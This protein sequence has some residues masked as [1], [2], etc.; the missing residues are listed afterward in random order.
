MGV[1][2]R[3]LSVSALPLKKWAERLGRVVLTTGGGIKNSTINGYLARAVGDTKNVI[4]TVIDTPGQVII[5]EPA[6]PADGT[7][8]AVGDRDKYDSRSGSI[9]GPYTRVDIPVATYTITPEPIGFALDTPAWLASINWPSHVSSVRYRDRLRAGWLRMTTPDVYFEYNTTDQAPVDAAVFSAVDVYQRSGSAPSYVFSESAIAAMAPGYQLLCRTDLGY[10]RYEYQGG[11]MA[12][13]TLGT[14]TLC[15]IPVVKN[16]DP[17]QSVHW[18]HSGLLF[19]LMDSAAEE[20]TVWSQLWT[21]DGH[22]STFFHNGEFVA[23]T[24][25]T[26]TGFRAPATDAWNDF[27]ETNTS[28]GSRPNWVDGLD[29]CAFNGRFV[30]SARVCAL[31]GLPATGLDDQYMCGGSALM[32]FDVAPGGG[33]TATE[34]SHEV[35]AFALAAAGA[36]WDALYQAWVVGVLDPLVVKLENPVGLIVDRGRLIE[37][38]TRIDGDR[39][40]PLFLGGSIESP[41][42]FPEVYLDTARLVVRVTAVDIAGVEAAPVAHE[43]IFSTLGVGLTTPTYG[44]SYVPDPAFPALTS[45]VLSYKLWCG[46]VQAVLVSENELA[47]VM[48]TRWDI[49]YRDGT[50]YP[51]SL[52][53]IDLTTGAA[54]VRGT[55]GL[56]VEPDVQYTRAPHIDC[57]QQTVFAEDGSVAIE[58]VLLV[59]TRENNAVRIS[60]DSGV[61]WADYITFPRPRT[62]AYYVGSPLMAGV[63]HGRAIS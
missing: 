47:V 45:P 41:S 2:V 56:S 18:G 37:L 36:G 52:V 50:T 34:I 23:P 39:A 42:T 63:P 49:A 20:P 8:Y 9:D 7:L 43:V 6:D 10:M 46:G 19:V 35:W 13:A 24:A 11:A 25:F 57:I 51:I 3:I 5:P 30:V 16:F 53:V 21:P 32:R 12:T 40:T 60:R 28:G 62:G 61:T 29:V 14:T 17:A 22:S 31:N 44:G 55:I 58:G 15:V 26:L 27:W 38:R 59:S 33:L 1:I 54:S 4:V 48:R